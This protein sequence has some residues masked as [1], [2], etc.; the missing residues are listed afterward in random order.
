MNTL[1][2][3]LSLYLILAVILAQFF[4][5]YFFQREKQAIVRHSLPWC[6]VLVF[7]YLVI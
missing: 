2:I 1:K 7:I 6:S 3:L 5:A 4:V